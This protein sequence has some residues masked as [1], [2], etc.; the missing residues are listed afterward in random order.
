M[1]MIMTDRLYMTL[2]VDPVVLVQTFYSDSQIT[3]LQ[4]LAKGR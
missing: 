2:A 3:Y 1:K 4:T